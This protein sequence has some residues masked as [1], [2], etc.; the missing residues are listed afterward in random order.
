MSGIG[1]QL[2]PH[3]AK[4][5]RS[6]DD[7]TTLNP[8]SPPTKIRAT[9]RNVDTQPRRVLGPSMPP[10]HNEEEIGLD[11]SSDDEPGSSL[12]PGAMPAPEPKPRRV[13]GPAMPP[14][15]NTDEIPLDDTLLSERPTEDPD[16]SSDDDYGPSLPPAPGSA[17]AAAAES[18]IRAHETARAATATASAASSAPKRADW[19]LVPP[20][21]DDWTSRVDPT[22]LKTRKFASGKGAKALGEKS[23]V[24]AI[25]TETPEEKRQRLEDEVLGRKEVATNSGKNGT[26]GAGGGQGEDEAEQAAIA[27]R[28]RGYNERMRGKSMVEEHTGRQ[29]GK[30]EEDDPSKRGFDKEKDMGLGGRIGHVQ[31]Q[32]MLRKAGDFGSRFE[33]G[34]FL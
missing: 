9:S 31:K 5:K 29:G 17:A 14:P 33:R 30:E 15:Q 2:P 26:R 4:R 24:S 10:T 28:I 22:K 12:P 19:M 20:G 21:A 7:T 3:L 18:A 16:S 13:M 25:W 27:K 11:S 32:E 8:P 34:K 1:P 23:G 6:T